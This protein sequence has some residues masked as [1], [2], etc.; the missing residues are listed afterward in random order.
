[1][2]INETIVTGRKIRKLVNGATKQWQRISLWHKAS[3]C[4]FDDGKTA[5]EKLGAIDGITDSL[6]NTSS[7]IAASAKSVAMLN[8]NLNGNILTYNESEDAYYIQHGADAVPKKLGSDVI[9]FTK[10]HSTMVSDKRTTKTYSVS[11]L[12]AGEY[13]VQSETFIG[14]GESIGHN[15]PTN[16]SITDGTIKQIASGIGLYKMSVNSNSNLQVTLNG[17]TGSGDWAYYVC[18]VINI[19]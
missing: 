9:N 8:N 3:D 6:D 14:Y 19:N 2:E 1:M 4:E 17:G 7:R 5:E 13:I 10:I 16:L 18:N 15:V 11:D 12:K